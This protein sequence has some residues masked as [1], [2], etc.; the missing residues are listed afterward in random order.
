MMI[1]TQ[2]NI[3]NLVVLLRSRM[4]EDTFDESQ[5][6]SFLSIAL[7]AYNSTPDFTMYSFD[8]T[9]AMEGLAE[10][11]L[12]GAEII[13]LS[14]QDL[15]LSDITIY[16]VLDSDWQYRLTEWYDLVQRKKI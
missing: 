15:E 11:L 13:A 5:Y 3:S 6:E 14:C 9:D 7:E 2:E 10:I 1:E 16:D 12:Q 4:P 8:D